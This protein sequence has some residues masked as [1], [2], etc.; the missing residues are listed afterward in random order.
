MYAHIMH[1]LCCVNG[2]GLDDAQLKLCVKSKG[3]LWDAN[4]STNHTRLLHLAGPL[5]GKFI[6][7]QVT[8][9]FNPPFVM[10]VLFLGFG[11]TFA[12]SLV[13]SLTKKM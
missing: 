4:S 3:Y 10:R 13:A 11:A 9:Y 8:V 2:L 1:F 5:T 12:T 7:L 6:E